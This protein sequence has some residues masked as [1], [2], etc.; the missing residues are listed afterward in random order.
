MCSTCPYP[1]PAGAIFNARPLQKGLP[2][3]PGVCTGGSNPCANAGARIATKKFVGKLGFGNTHLRKSPGNR[4]NTYMSPPP[5][6]PRTRTE[7]FLFGRAAT[8][9]FSP[10]LCSPATRDKFLVTLPEPGIIYF[11]YPRS[12]Y[13]PDFAQK[14][15][16]SAVQTNDTQTKR[17]KGTCARL[18]GNI[19]PFRA[20]LPGDGM[21]WISVIFNAEHPG[22]SRARMRRRA[23][24]GT[25]AWP[26]LPL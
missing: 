2:S 13:P 6:P 23:K 10:F 7:L 12:A 18:Q 14:S 20:E 3:A 19:H 24:S 16:R 8:W 5:P 1:T 17:G 22:I 15:R 25:P 9:R 26:I 11:P 21:T 4:T